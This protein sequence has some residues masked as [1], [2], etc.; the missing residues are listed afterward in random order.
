MSDL[1][2][3]RAQALESWETSEDTPYKPVQFE[4]L[5][6]PKK[7]SPYWR[8]FHWF[9]LITN[10]IGGAVIGPVSVFLPCKKYGLFVNLAW[11]YMPMTL[12][13]IA[14]VIANTAYMH[15]F[16]VPIEK[17]PTDSPKKK[18]LVI[19]MMKDKEYH[20]LVWAASLC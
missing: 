17:L 10:I 13:L 4:P 7:Q 11:R 8:C 18:Y 1:E 14:A 19:D 9:N 12:W 2:I 3:K 6:E 15:F 5:E 16:K 20:M